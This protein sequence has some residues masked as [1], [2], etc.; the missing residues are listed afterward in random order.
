MYGF[1]LVVFNRKV[2]PV[3]VNSILARSGSP[4][5]GLVCLSIHCSFIVKHQQHGKLWKQLFSILGIGVVGHRRGTTLNNG[6]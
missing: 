6:F 3:P 5:I 1:V 2:I 4:V